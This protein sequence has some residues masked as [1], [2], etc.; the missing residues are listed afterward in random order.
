M[1]AASDQGRRIGESVGQVAKEICDIHPDWFE[2]LK[3][4]VEEPVMSELKSKAKAEMADYLNSN[5]NYFS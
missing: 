2:T 3:L 4:H 1:Q 5:R